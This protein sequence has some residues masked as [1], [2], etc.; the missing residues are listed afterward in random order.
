MVTG[1]NRQVD[2]KDNKYALSVG[3]YYQLGVHF[4]EN[5]HEFHDFQDIS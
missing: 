2:M 4:I 5:L 1:R 3:T